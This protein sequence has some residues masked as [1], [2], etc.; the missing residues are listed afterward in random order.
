[1]QA[2]AAVQEAVHAAVQREVLEQQH[3]EAL[4]EQ[5]ANPEAD[6]YYLFFEFFDQGR[7]SFG[8]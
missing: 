5:A 3:Q 7:K 1:M 8:L 6:K 2:R 4:Q